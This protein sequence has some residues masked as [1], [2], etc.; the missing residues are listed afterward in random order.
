MQLNYFVVVCPCVVFDRFF[1]RH[2]YAI[3]VW[4]C[5]EIYEIIKPTAF[6]KTACYQALWAIIG[7]Y[8]DMKTGR[9]LSIPNFISFTS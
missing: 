2:F 7:S 6:P 9:V 5:V 3:F 1:L 4:S 8:G